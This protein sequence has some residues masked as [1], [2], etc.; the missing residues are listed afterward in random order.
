MSVL[1]QFLDST[2]AP[3][4][5]LSFGTLGSGTISP[6]IAITI[7]NGKGV[8]TADPLTELYIGALVKGSTDAAYN[9]NSVAVTQG[10][11]EAQVTGIAP[12]GTGSPQPYTSGWAKIAP[13]RPLRLP[14]IPADS[15]YSVSFRVNAP[16]GQ[17]SDS[18]SFKL[19]P[20]YKEPSLPIPVGLWSAGARGV[21]DGCGDS[22]ASFLIAGGGLTASGTPD[23]N[24][25]LAD[26]QYRFQGLPKVCLEQAIAFDQHDGAGATLAAGQAYWLAL[27]AGAG[28]LLTVTKGLAAAYP[29]ALSGRPVLPVGEPL[30]GYVQV[31]QTA[32][33]L[34]GDIDQTLTVWG[35][36][37][38]Y[39]ISSLNATLGP[40]SGIVGDSFDMTAS[41]V[42]ILF[43]DNSTVSVWKV[44]SNPDLIWQAAKPHPQAL[45]LWR[46]TTLSGAITAVKDVRRWLGPDRQRTTLFLYGGVGAELAYGVLPG[47]GDR[48]LVLPAPM[49]LRTA[50]LA[51]ATG[52]AEFEV[53]Y[54][55]G[56]VWV[57]LFT[58]QATQ[59]RRPTVTPSAPA[60]GDGTFY[61]V[62]ALPEVLVLPGYTQLRF[63]QITDTTPGVASTDGAFIDIWT[64]A[65]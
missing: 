10:Y 9:S 11:L 34:A 15:G 49:M 38:L 40:G 43:P 7:W 53:D 51:S 39:G 60:A 17:L 62:G 4:G 28:P 42:S 1:P 41:P 56:S 25:H 52:P 16:I 45:E 32:A 36:W 50:M 35:G 27:T 20:H 44:P 65:A 23:N 24:V 6:T 58:N 64:E 54:W 55:N 37:L 30:V 26:L 13:G 33:I 61:S 57:T 8:P 29:V 46:V 31:P 48:A 3:L 14:T 5:A 59:D 18:Y 19:D 12:G 21:F 22:E 2:G 63:Q 47:P